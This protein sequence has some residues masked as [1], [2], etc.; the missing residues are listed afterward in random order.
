MADLSKIVPVSAP[1]SP[2]VGEV[3]GEVAGDETGE[4]IEVNTPS[5]TSIS[6]G[7]S[8]AG[9]KALQPD[10]S[11][12]SGP[13]P[14]ETAAHKVGSVQ[15]RR[16]KTSNEFYREKVTQRTIIRDFCEDPGFSKRAQYSMG[17]FRALS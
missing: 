8:G 7:D 10:G 4:S 17:Y 6:D 3:V 15:Y 5:G 14:S 12:K 1:G 2:A 13:R 9:A 16:R 11:K